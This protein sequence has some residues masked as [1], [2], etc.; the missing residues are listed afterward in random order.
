MKKK[1]SMLFTLAMVVSV[2]LTGCFGAYTSPVNAPQAV[3]QVIGLQPA[4]TLYGLQTVMANKAPGLG[5]M[6][7]DNMYLFSWILKDSQT[8]G[9]VAFKTGVSGMPSAVDVYKQ[10]SEG[11]TGNTT[12][13]Q[14]WNIL[15]QY[16]LT[17]GWQEMTPDNMPP[18]IKVGI[19]TASISYQRALIPVFAVGTSIYYLDQ[20]SQEMLDAR[21]H[22][23]VIQ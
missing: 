9:F 20:Q 6:F 21:L 13:A 14:T 2:L 7:K 18:A 16:L 23:R 11:I 3:G 15:K 17:K 10:I 8:V 22:P 1:Y 5:M 12:S 4:T 19:L